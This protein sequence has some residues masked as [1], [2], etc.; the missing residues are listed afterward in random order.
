MKNEQVHELLYQALETELGG[1]FTRPHFAR[2]EQGFEERVAG[3]GANTEPCGSLRRQWR[4]G[5]DRD[6]DPGRAV[7]RHTGESLV[8]AMEMA[9]DSEKR[10]AAR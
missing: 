8:K 9:L 4:S 1:A 7:V 3:V 5:L 10:A 6:R 2:T